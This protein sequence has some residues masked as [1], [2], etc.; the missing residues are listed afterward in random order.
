VWNDSTVA[1]AAGGGGVS[2]LFSRPSYQNGVVPMNRREV[3]DVAMLADL[4][5]GYSIYC[6]APA[7]VNSQNSSPW[8]TVGGTSA[9]TPLLAG[10][11]ALVDQMLQATGHYNL[12]LLNPMLYEIGRSSASASVFG[13]VTSGDND[14]GPYIPGGNGAPLGC[15]TATPGWDDASGWGAVSV[16]GLAAQAAALVPKQVAF[17]LALPGRQRPVAHRE[18]LAKVSC[19]AACAYGAYAM[20]KIGRSTFAVNSKLY[21]LTSPGGKTVAMKFSKSQLR[22]LRSAL[23]HHRKITATIYGAVVDTLGDI[24]QQ[25]PGR[26]LRI[27]S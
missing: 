16:S 27:S 1:P 21:H 9:G 14:L 12:G 10:G 25:T 20:V 24:Q 15:C 23:T 17:S 2:T 8:L 13:D 19:S 6:T 5:P 22:R 3:P 26:R 4:L 7:C 11:V 18:L